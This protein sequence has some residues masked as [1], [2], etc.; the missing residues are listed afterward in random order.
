MNNIQ[1]KIWERKI[2]RNCKKTNSF[3]KKGIGLEL[4]N[5]IYS[6][7][8]YEEELDSQYFPLYGYFT[9]NSFITE[10]YVI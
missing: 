10:L 5:N 9:S 4:Y 7:Y 6:K 2:K 3:D 1:I 8:K